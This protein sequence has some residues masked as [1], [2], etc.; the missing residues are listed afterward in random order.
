[1]KS[2]AVRAITGLSGIYLGSEH[3]RE[4]EIHSRLLFYLGIYDAG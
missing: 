2:K 3:R 1:M 4:C